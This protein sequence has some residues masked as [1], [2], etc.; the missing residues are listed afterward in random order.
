MS[1]WISNQRWDGIHFL[2]IQYTSSGLAETPV[3]HCNL[4]HTRW[5]TALI[6][7]PNPSRLI[8]LVPPPALIILVPPSILSIQSSLHHPLSIPF[9]PPCAAVHPFHPIILAPSVAHPV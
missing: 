6:T 4:P 1:A 5:L 2:Q 7:A 9:N 3:K 8:P